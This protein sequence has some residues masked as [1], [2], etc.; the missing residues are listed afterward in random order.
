MGTK[1]ETNA[2]VSLNKTEILT[3]ISNNLPEEF[4]ALEPEQKL[5]F[6]VKGTL[7]ILENQCGLKGNYLL[8]DSSKTLWELL[9][10]SKA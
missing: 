4:D 9:Q 8:I 2:P 6:L 5:H 3:E 1:Q 7:D 10:D